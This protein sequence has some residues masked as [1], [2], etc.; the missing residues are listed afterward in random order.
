MAED[1]LFFRSLARVDPRR[2]TPVASLWAQ[3]A[4]S[5]LLTVTGTYSQLY[6][7]VVFA[8]VGSSKVTIAATTS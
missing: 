7:Y 6:T 1:G 2:R 5:L 3:T 4:W 8:S